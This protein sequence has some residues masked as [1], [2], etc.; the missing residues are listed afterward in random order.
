MGWG[1]R[2]P[3]LGAAML[4][5]GCGN[6]GRVAG[7]AVM[8]LSTVGSVAAGA[9]GACGQRGGRR[10]RRGRAGDRCR[11][12]GRRRRCGRRSGG[13]G[14]PG[15]R[16][17]TGRS[18]RAAGGGTAS[19]TLAAGTAA[20]SLA[21]V[22]ILRRTGRDGSC[23]AS[24]L[25]AGPRPPADRCALQVFLGGTGESGFAQGTRFALWLG[26]GVRDAGERHAFSGMLI[27]ADS[28]AREVGAARLAG[29][30][31]EE[32]AEEGQPG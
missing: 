23:R 27:L 30:L 3:V 4:L 22:E 8:G 6:S 14:G 28:M 29:L 17:R 11:G 15:C 1:A 10:A 25:L 31:A 32:E 16:S 9:V 18:L 26:E 13:G 19:A 2:V 12:F 5:G 24:E 21:R 20:A 7:A